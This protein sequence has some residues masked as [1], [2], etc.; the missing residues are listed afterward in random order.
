MRNVKGFFCLLGYVTWF[1]PSL[2]LSGGGFTA[3]NRNQSACPLYVSTPTRPNIHSC[4][5]HSR[6]YFFFCSAVPL[7][8]FFFFAVIVQTFL[9]IT[10]SIFVMNHAPPPPFSKD[11]TLSQFTLSF[12]LSVLVI[13]SCRFF[14]VY[15]MSGSKPFSFFTSSQ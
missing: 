10:L 13:V 8:S 11:V 2:N 4:S 9:I 7:S 12:I 15:I 6:P 14:F 3:D 1:F 5:S